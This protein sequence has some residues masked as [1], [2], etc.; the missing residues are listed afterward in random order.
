MNAK[1]KE[2]Q[3]EEKRKQVQEDKRRI[4]SFAEEVEELRGRRWRIKRLG[5]G[6]TNRNYLLSDGADRYVVRIFGGGGLDINRDREVAILNTIAAAGVGPKVIEY[7]PQHSALVMAF[8]P[9]KTLENE[10]LRRPGMIARIA[11]V[12]RR[13]HDF[14]PPAG[15][16]SFCPFAVARDYHRKARRNVPLPD[17]VKVALQAMSAIEDELKKGA[18]PSR[19]CHNDLLAANF[20]DDGAVLRL[21]DW[22]YGALGD[23]FF[24]LGNLAVNVQLSAA[25]EETLLKCYCRAA[26]PADL[27]RL[28]LMR[29]ASDMR[30]AMWSF[31]QACNKK[32]PKE[33][34][35]YLRRGRKH[36]KRFLVANRGLANAGGRG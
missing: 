7:L 21:I 13:C 4:R 19:L 5:G 32:A 9:G 25:E 22:E 1:E 34:D 31:L 30:E 12:L 15:L 18:G 14:A 16:T 8:C 6:L 35:Y 29:L 17:E 24:D 36:L 26:R 33:P 11:A 10:D 20:I 28:R 3:K 23:R 2:R 27:R